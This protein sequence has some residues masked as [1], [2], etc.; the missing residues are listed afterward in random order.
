MYVHAVYYYIKNRKGGQSNRRLF[1]LNDT[2]IKLVIRLTNQ[3]ILLYFTMLAIM[4]N[5]QILV[6]TTWWY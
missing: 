2:A 1:D 5:G 3:L 4:N 6:L